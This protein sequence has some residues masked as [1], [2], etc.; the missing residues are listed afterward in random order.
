MIHSA[1]RYCSERSGS[2]FSGASGS[3]AKSKTSPSANPGLAGRGI[4]AY[5]PGARDCRRDS[6]YQSVVP[7]RC[8]L[9][10]ITSGYWASECFACLLQLRHG[11][12]RY[13]APLPLNA[14]PHHD[15]VGAALVAS[16]DPAQKEQRSRVM[17]PN[18]GRLAL[19]FNCVSQ[20]EREALIIRRRVRGPSAVPAR[21]SPSRYR[22]PRHGHR[23]GAGVLQPR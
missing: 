9:M 5:S 10:L 8:C 20:L 4:S 6:R 23:L 22:A 17:H 12:F 1:P 13:L 15:Q 11:I 2:E 21:A 14:D 19:E 18:R 3:I 16:R 7:T